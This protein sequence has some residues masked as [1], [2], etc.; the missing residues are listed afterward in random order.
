MKKLLPGMAAPK[1]PVSTDPKSVQNMKK[2][3]GTS[4]QMMGQEPAPVSPQ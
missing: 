2:P 1:T 3:L 4:Q